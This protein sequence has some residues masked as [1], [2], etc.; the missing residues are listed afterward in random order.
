MDV[1]FPVLIKSANA[2][3]K[4][5]AAAVPSCAVISLSD[6]VI[7]VALDSLGVDIGCVGRGVD[8]GSTGIDIGSSGVGITSGGTVIEELSG[9]VETISGP[10]A[11]IVSAGETTCPVVGWFP[12]LSPKFPAPGA[13]V[14]PP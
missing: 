10:G 3:L 5:N 6:K 7:G 14:P 13:V 11:D 2:K 9:V 8:I 4:F 12:A 1:K